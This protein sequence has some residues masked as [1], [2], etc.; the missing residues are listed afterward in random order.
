MKNADV[1]LSSRHSTDNLPPIR[2][3]IVD[4]ITVCP[5]RENTAIIFDYILCIL[6]F[7]CNK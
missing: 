6:S 5:G 4:F 1:N 2:F 7:A 3:K